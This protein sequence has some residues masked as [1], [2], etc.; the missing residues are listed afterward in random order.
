MGS[1]KLDSDKLDSDGSSDGG[2]V[3]DVVMRTLDTQRNRDS[4]TSLSFK[5][6]STCLRN[7]NLLKGTA[8]RSLVDSRPTLILELKSPH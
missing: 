5:D 4:F 2:V 7:Y 8:M 6:T 1:D 3:G